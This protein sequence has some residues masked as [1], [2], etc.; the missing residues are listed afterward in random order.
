[1][2]DLI[3][4]DAFQ[5]SVAEL[6]GAAGDL[7]AGKVGNHGV[8]L[9]SSLSGGAERK[10]RRLAD[11]ADRIST[12][13]GRRFGLSLHF[14]SSAASRSLPL[15]RSYQAALQAAERAL[16]RGVR[17]TES[18]PRA[19]EPIQSLRRMRE[20]LCRA[21]E[22]SPD[23]LGAR[24]DRY[25][26]TV[27]AQSGYRFDA[28]AGHL[29]AGFELMAR[30][31][32]AKGVLDAKSFAALSETLDRAGGEAR[33]TS[34][35]FA[36]YRSAVTDMALAM[37]RPVPARRERRLH[38]ALDFIH[39][40]YTEP[41]SFRQIAKMAG[42]APNYFSA[43]FREREGVPFERYVT[44]LRLERAKQL[45]T[46]STF[47]AARIGE[48]AGFGS[49]QYFSKVFHRTLGVTPLEYRR[50]PRQR[51]TRSREQSK[52]D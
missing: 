18:E 2:G 16:A 14:G 29:A 27:E 12:L 13:G 11:L 19:S 35:L 9:L 20:E 6:A 40:H 23:S 39:Q 32:V 28:V 47:S 48:L 5:R 50:R 8:L 46:S 36:A 15:S 10:K 37:A 21:V 1:V 26:E 38:A 22:E 43:L 17:I 41:L 45:L 51:R 42:F 44:G 25:L 7:V 33:T 34:D 24:F 3:R 49:A 52:S 4:R 30:P 31:L